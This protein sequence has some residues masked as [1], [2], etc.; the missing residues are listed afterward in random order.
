M[1]FPW[2][3][4]EGSVGSTTRKTT[5][6]LAVATSRLKEFVGQWNIHR[7]NELRS[8]RPHVRLFFEKE[9]FAIKTV[10]SSWELEA[11]LKLRHD[12]FYEEMQQRR[13]PL[14]FDVDAFDLR[15]D[16]LVIVEIKTNRIVGTYRLNATAYSR[17][18]YS[19]KEFDLGDFLRT[20]GPKLELGRACIHKNFRNG[21]VLSLL[22]KGILQYAECVGAE[23]MFGC[24]SIQ[25]V[26]RLDALTVSLYFERQGYALPGIEMPPR[27]GYRFPHW[28][29]YRIQYAPQN[30]E[31][32]SNGRRLVPALLLGYLRIGARVGTQPALD[33]AFQC[34]DFMTVL[35]TKRI[36]ASYEK[37]FSRC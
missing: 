6:L 36:A 24:S 11:A 2:D 7:K 16:H 27:A 33:R 5:E 26:Q 31:A 10:E 9:S 32:I 35:E 23:T 22:W 3:D 29:E 12:V 14:G 20:P 8:F 17:D 18:F 15:C 25:T 34:V 19:N 37:K 21:A 1:Y 30:P 13:S 4:L 28:D